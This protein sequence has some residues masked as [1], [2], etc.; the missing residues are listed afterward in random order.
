[1]SVRWRNEGRKDSEEA[2]EGGWRRGGGRNGLHDLTE[3][4]MMSPTTTA[5]IASTIIRM[6]I[7]FL[8]LRCE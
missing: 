3:P 8:E 2:E 6:Q 5:A 1:M 7:F 4:Q